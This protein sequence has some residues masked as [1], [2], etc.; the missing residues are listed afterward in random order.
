MRT[1]ALVLRNVRQASQRADVNRIPG[2]LN[3]GERKRV[4]V[5]EQRRRFD[6]DLHEIENVRAARNVA[7]APFAGELGQGGRRARWLRVTE[8][9]H[10][11]PAASS[12][13]STMCG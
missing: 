5:D 9:V 10:D 2:H 13:A 7:R 8:G 12:T 4:D 1:N 6:R 11:V 3:R